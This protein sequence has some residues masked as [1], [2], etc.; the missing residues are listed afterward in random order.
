M[1]RVL[2]SSIFISVIC[3]NTAFS[4]MLDQAVQAAINHNPEL[5][6]SR[7]EEDVA[8]G[9]R[10]K[11]KLPLI[12]NPV[13]ETSGSKKER[14]PEEGTGTVT[15][16]GARLSQQFEIAGQRGVR[17]D[18]AEKNLAKVMHDTRHRERSL[19]YE[20]KAAFARA[21]AGK[22]RVSLAGEVS[23]L[24]EE[25]LGFTHTKFQA[26]EVSALEVNLAEVQNSRAKREVLSAEREY[27]ESVLALATLMGLTS[28]RS[29]TL[30]GELSPELFLMPDKESLR[31]GLFQRPDVRAASAEVERAAGTVDLITREAVPNVTLAGFHDRDENRNETG[32]GLAISI[33]LF[34]RKQGEKREAQAR[35][36]QARIR[37]AGLERRVESEFETDYS[38][39]VSSQAEVSIFRK[40]IVAKAHENLELLNL[41][42]NEG[43]ISFFDVRLAQRET[44]EMQYAYL[45]ALLKAQQAIYALERTTGGAIK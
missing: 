34:D 40:E 36:S 19:I 26:G 43:K 9:Q 28:D 14:L 37:K 30:E 8:K 2:A 16:Y 7:L 42:F 22:K 10:D 17:I 45:D 24:Q 4:M 1:I 38:N 5:N 39:L 44:I 11:A 29:M 32:M 3:V 27:R 20:V 33:P 6:T 35:A 25:L 13:L 21:L 23:R 18:V 41:A 15:N 12:A 31:S